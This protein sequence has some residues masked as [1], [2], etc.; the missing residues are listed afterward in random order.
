MCRIEF[1]YDRQS[2]ILCK[3]GHAYCT[4]F[5]FKCTDGTH[6]EKGFIKFKTHEIRALMRKLVDSNPVKPSKAP[7]KCNF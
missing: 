6:Q 7:N 3:C 4:T 1:S 2:N 5:E